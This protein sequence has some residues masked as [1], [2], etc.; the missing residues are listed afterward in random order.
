MKRKLE[1]DSPLPHLPGEIWVNIS[2]FFNP[3]DSLNILK[4]CKNIYSFYDQW[5]DLIK[6]SYLSSQKLLLFKELKRKKLDFLIDLLNNEENSAIAGSFPLR[7]ISNKLFHYGDI[8]IFL[9]WK[10]SYKSENVNNVI[11]FK[12]SEQFRKLVDDDFIIINNYN[13]NDNGSR[14][15][16]PFLAHVKLISTFTGKKDY[17]PLIQFIFIDHDCFKDIKTY[18]NTYFDLSFCCSWFDGKKLDCDKETFFNILNKKGTINFKEIDRRK[19]VLSEGN[20]DECAYHGQDIIERVK[21]YKK[22]GF[23]IDNEDV[24]PEK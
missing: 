7:F 17:R 22:R 13:D 3:I 15:Y 10:E 11:F 4:T 9:P 24:L 16:Y 2:L 1:P 19:N 20:V 5:K 8:D 14:Y 12:Y 23:I 6:D 18:T 21:K